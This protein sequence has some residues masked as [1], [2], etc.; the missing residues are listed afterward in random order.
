VNVGVV[1]PTRAG[2][3]WRA[4]A[5][6]WVLAFYER[7]H[8]AWRVE[9][10]MLPDDVPWSKG[11]AVAAGVEALGPVDVLIL[12]DADSIIPDP[13]VLQRA[14]DLV[15]GS[16]R[17][18]VVPHRLVY[19]LRE[20]ETERLYGDPTNRPRPHSVCRTPYVG[21]AGG[22]ITVIAP[23][24]FDEVGGIDR[25]FLGWGGEDIAFGWALETLVHPIER[26]DGRLVHLW[27]PHPAPTLRG[28]PESEKLVATYTAA[29]GFPRRMRAVVAGEQWEP[30]APLLGTVAG[31]VSPRLSSSVTLSSTDFVWMNWGSSKMRS[32]PSYSCSSFA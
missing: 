32:P 3:A 8:R 22:G 23:S 25:R 18:W 11:A 14:V 29:R 10:G 19:R 15:G 4:R 24:A 5:L 1:I 27:H 2:D 30:L 31:A 13:A 28:S 6:G 26:L 21:P 16:W 7:N 9:L 17:R 20:T 12:A